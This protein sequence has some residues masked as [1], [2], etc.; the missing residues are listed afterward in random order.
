MTQLRD[1]QAVVLGGD[2]GAYSIARAFSEVTR[3]R[4]IVISA[5]GGGVV[6]HSTIADLVVAP[7]MEDLDALHARLLVL[8]RQVEAGHVIAVASADWNVEALLA[9]RDRLPERWIVPYPDA[10][11]VHR[12]TDKASFSQ[13]CE[14]LGIAHPAS[15]VRAPKEPVPIEGLTYP[16]VAKAC[17]TSAYHAVEFAGKKKVFTFETPSEAHE[18]LSRADAAGYRGEFLIQ[19]YVPGP[20]SQ[21]RVLNVYCQKGG[22]VVF[23]GLGRVLLEEHTPSAIGNS[24]AI[25]TEADQD[26]IEQASRIV[27]ELGWH[28][29]ACFD[30]KV[31]PRT[32]E[33]KILEL[34]AR[35]GRAHHYLTAVGANPAEYYLRD[36]VEGD[37]NI[38]SHVVERESLYTVVPISLLLAYTPGERSRILRLVARGRVASPLFNRRE[39]HPKRWA[40]ALAAYANQFRKFAR[41]HPPRRT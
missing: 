6:R 4:P 21:M 2:I 14:D 1:V 8:D 11:T 19:D 41:H 24:A 26:I 10:A 32:G 22:R 16:V 30:V 5:F 25:I 23:A 36:W 37:Q 17:D 7:D 35:L 40:Y 9:L 31:D 39:R 38:E 27:A 12:A 34:N 33:A 15:R 20:D 18:M 13:L 3:H 28:G 29:F